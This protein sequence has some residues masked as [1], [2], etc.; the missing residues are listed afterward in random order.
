MKRKEKSLK[1]NGAVKKL[2]ALTDKSWSRLSTGEQA[3]KLRNFRQFIASLKKK[4]R[5]KSSK[6][7]R[8]LRVVAVA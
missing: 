3:E 1:L 8:V 5:A 6:S 7:S 4:E 2:A